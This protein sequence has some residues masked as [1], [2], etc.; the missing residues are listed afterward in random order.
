MSS[1]CKAKCVMLSWTTLTYW[2]YSI[3]NRPVMA[4]IFWLI[5]LYSVHFIP[6]SLLTFLI[7]FYWTHFSAVSHLGHDLIERWDFRF[8]QKVNKWIKEQNAVTAAKALSQFVYNIMHCHVHI[9]WRSLKTVLFNNSIEIN[10]MYFV[11]M[12]STGFNWKCFMY[13]GYGNLESIE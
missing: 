8:H 9:V 5:S 7:G 10:F 4:I 3:N 6:L 2:F 12:G 1:L 11:F 13:L